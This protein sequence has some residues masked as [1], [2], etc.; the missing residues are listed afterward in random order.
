MKPLAGLR[1][2]DL[3]TVLAGPYS[4]SLLA[5]L[6]ADVIK[7]EPP[8]GD[9]ARALVTEDGLAP[10][11][12]TNQ[13]NK[14]S[15]VIDLKHRVG[16]KAFDGL[17]RWADVVLENYRPGVTRRLGIDY[18]ALAA[19]NPRII[20]C[21]ITGYGLTGPGK[22]RAAFD[23]NIQAYAGIMGLTG[24]PEGMPVRAAPAYADLCAGM[25][26]ALGI[27]AAVVARERSGRGQ[28]VDLAMLDVQLSMQNY[29]CTMQLA[30]RPPRRLGNEHELHVPYNAYRAAYGALFVTVVTEA[31][32]SGLLRALGKFDYP[33][34]ARAHVAM[35]ADARLRERG[36]RIRS[37]A[38][39]NAALAALFVTRPRAEWMEALAAER[40]PFAPVNT[41][42]ETL[43]G[44]QVAARNMVA[45]I[46][47]PDGGT[48]R[49]PGNP[50][51]L[52]DAGP[53]TYTPPPLLGQHTREVLAEVLGYDET[54][55]AGLLASGAFTA[56][57]DPHA[58]G[59]HTAPAGGG[60][61]SGSAE[62]GGAASRCG[63]EADR[64]VVTRRDECCGDTAKGTSGAG[65]RSGGDGTGNGPVRKGGA[66]GC[67]E[68][69]A[70]RGAVT[71]CEPGAGAG[72][73]ASP[74]VAPRTA[75]G[76]G[77]SATRVAASP[78]AAG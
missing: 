30:R 6:G 44:P 20:M 39:I 69:A 12:H 10:H 58:P 76:P 47:L 38:A 59:I 3:S 22:D 18:P 49:A 55:I 64:G 11:L 36:N 65:S 8:S 21:S 9:A 53:D 34:A 4:A 19:L 33:P 75:T 73:A 45:R 37:R 32:W 35:L 51:K 72:A 46:P 68:A 7:V 5:D 25:A 60:T 70:D 26:G 67:S 15:I 14:R 41:L 57:A 74:G 31:Q 66:P 50:I 56:S 54:T 17:V 29:F 16:R 61:R 52:S 63:A 40:L 71:W 23:A 42:E 43:A 48:L 27:L 2:I 1:L 62:E 28:H 13:R 78:G 77:A 24:D